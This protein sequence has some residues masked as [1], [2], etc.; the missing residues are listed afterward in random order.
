VTIADG[1]QGTGKLLILT[2][3]L[4]S[5]HLGF[6]VIPLVTSAADRAKMGELGALPWLIVLSILIAVIIMGLNMKL[7]IE[8]FGAAG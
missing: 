3:V 5:L 2:G 7:L 4:L 1:S 8:F 6:A